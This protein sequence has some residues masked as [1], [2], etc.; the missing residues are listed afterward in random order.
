MRHRIIEIHQEMF[1]Y[2]EHEVSKRW[3]FEEGVSVFF[4]RFQNI[5]IEI[6]YFSFRFE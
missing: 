4:N 3:T 2:N 6:M 1:N 5:K